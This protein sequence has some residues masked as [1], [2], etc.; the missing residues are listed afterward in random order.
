MIEYQHL[1]NVFTQTGVLIKTNRHFH[2]IRLLL[3]IVGILN[4]DQ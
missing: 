2:K 1:M 4:G 3:F